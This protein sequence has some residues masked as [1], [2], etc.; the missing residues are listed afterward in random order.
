[1]GCLALMVQA[2]KRCK[3]Y[4]DAHTAQHSTGLWVRTLGSFGL[5]VG[6]MHL[7]GSFSSNCTNSVHWRGGA[8]RDG[9]HVQTVRRRGI[10]LDLQAPYP[11]DVSPLMGGAFAWSASNLRV[12][13]AKPV[14]WRSA[15]VP[16]V[17]VMDPLFRTLCCVSAGIALGEWACESKILDSCQRLLHEHLRWVGT[18]WGIPTQPGIAPSYKLWIY[19]ED[20]LLFRV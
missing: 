13:G 16:R 11:S 4:V 8:A 15:C 19:L 20:F 10:S 6:L 18:A 14:L 3:R 7:F 5:F 17:V 1:M 2:F 9:R 12:N